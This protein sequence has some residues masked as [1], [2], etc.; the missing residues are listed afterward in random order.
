MVSGT[1][2]AFFDNMIIKFKVASF[3]ETDRISKSIPLFLTNKGIQSGKETAER[4]WDYQLTATDGK[5]YEARG[6]KV[7]GGFR[8]GMTIMTDLSGNSVWI[9][10]MFSESEFLKIVGDRI[11]RRK[12]EIEVAQKEIDRLRAL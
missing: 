6:R 10:R 7:R 5:V 8:K 12:K 11:D 9:G 1:S 2:V 4:V 3:R